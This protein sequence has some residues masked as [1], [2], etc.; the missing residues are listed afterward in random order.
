MMKQ[1]AVRFLCCAMIVGR[2]ILALLIILRSLPDDF[3]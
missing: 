2:D 1:A 3:G